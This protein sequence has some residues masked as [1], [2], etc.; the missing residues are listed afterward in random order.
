MTSCWIA[1]CFPPLHGLS[2][3]VAITK[4][5]QL[6]SLPRKLSYGLN[7]LAALLKQFFS[8]SAIRRAKWISDRANYIGKS[9]YIPEPSIR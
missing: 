1:C 8:E 6:Y 4:N 2:I 3:L 9:R 7:H 5:T